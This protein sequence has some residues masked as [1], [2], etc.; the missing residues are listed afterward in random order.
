MFLVP[1]TV[2]RRN[3]KHAKEVA[4]LQ[5]QIKELMTDNV[6]TEDM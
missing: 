3:Q 2:A 6:T 5:K 4:R 1:S